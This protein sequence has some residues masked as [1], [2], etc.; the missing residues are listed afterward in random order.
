MKNIRK[1]S[2]QRAVLL[3]D[4]KETF[5]WQM[6]DKYSSIKFH[7]IPCMRTDGRTYMTELLATFSNLTRLIKC[8]L[9]P[10]LPKPEI[11][12]KI[13]RKF[14]GKSPVWSRSKSGG[15]QA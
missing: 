6:F 3:S 11:V 9:C 4:L 12:N 15:E 7:E 2:C 5:S 10:F 13:N 1:S 14:S 8:K